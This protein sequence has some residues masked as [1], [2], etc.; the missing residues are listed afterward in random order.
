VRQGKGHFADVAVRYAEQVV[1]GEIVACQN[2]K[3]SCA[4]FLADVKG[5]TW[6]FHAGKVERVCRFAETFP[7]LEGPLASKRLLLRLEPWQVWILAALFGLVD[8]HGLRKHR[9]AFIEIPRKN[10]KSTFAAVVALY[11]LVADAEARAQVYIGANNLQQADFCFQPCREMA[12][13]AKG[14][15]GHW[16]AVVTKKKIELPD[17]S[18][19]ERMIGKPGDGGNPHCAILDEAHENDSDDQR[20][21]MKT[22]MGARE[23][24]LLVTITTAG[25]NTAGP[26]RDL[27]G[28][29]VQIL[30][31]ELK[32]DRHFSAIYGIDKEDD[33]RDFEVW[34]K[35]NPNVGVS[36]SVETLREFYQTAL[37]KPS[38]KPKL[39]TKH[40]NVWQSSSNAWVN[41]KDWDD[42]A[43]APALEELPKG[44]RAWIGCD[45]S[46]LL[47]TTA[48]VLLVEHESKLYA[49][50]TIF[51]P[52]MAIER[53]AKNANAYREWGDAG[54]IT[55]T[56]DEETD[57]AAVEQHI[58]NLCEQFNV[59]SVGM[60][61]WQASYLSQRLFQDSVPIITYPQNYQNIHPA[62]SKFEKELAL[63]NLKVA[64]NPCFRWMAG[65]VCA[66]YH[67]EFMKA[68]KPDRRPHAKIDAFV[69]LMMAVG[70]SIR[71]EVKPRKIEMFVLD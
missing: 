30:A 42:N 54:H 70:L 62:M 31:G 13:R 16:G 6:T 38:E 41:M 2:I 53:E 1:A 29:S 56:E 18:F 34:K 44:L 19:L 22:G 24:P 69:S 68:V 58:R 8:Q 14:F 32:N 35:A 60:D 4:A 7:Y 9:E 37:D 64:N 51:L 49:Y 63:G 59:Q 45:L 67:G 40:L 12:T 3:L 47:D 26:C 15:T 27:E 65:N 10:G 52:K 21:T 39:L 5:D 17:G 11:M 61:Q 23:Q 43:T 25:F 66:K 33:W 55:L 28:Y 36:F 20:L 46:K 48:I 71:D 50:P 57:F